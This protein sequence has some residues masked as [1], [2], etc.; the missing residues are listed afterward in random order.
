MHM[1]LLELLRAFPDTMIIIHLIN[2]IGHQLIII[3]LYKP[4]DLLGL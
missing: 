1:Y 2:R 3:F 4:Y